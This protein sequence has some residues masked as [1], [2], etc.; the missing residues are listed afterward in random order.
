M[1]DV[2]VRGHG[3]K[4]IP[5]C[6]QIEFRSKKIKFLALDDPQ[7]NNNMLIGIYPGLLV[8]LLYMNYYIVYAAGGST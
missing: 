5:R 1:Y 7:S 3:L 4:S 2:R 6:L 8:K